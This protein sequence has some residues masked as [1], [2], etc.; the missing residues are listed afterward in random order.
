MNK[1]IK[2]MNKNIE[3][4]RNQI[5]NTLQMLQREKF[6]LYYNDP[7][8]RY[9]NSDDTYTISWNNHKSGRSVSSGCFLR[10]GQYLQIVKDNAYFALL[11]DYS[12][13]RGSFTY[14]NKGNLLCE[15]LLWWP[16]PVNVDR[17]A[18]EELGVADAVELILYE[19]KIASQLRM[20]TP[21]RIDFDYSNDTSEHPAAHMHMQHENCRINTIE[22][23]CFNKFIRYITKCFY[24]GINIK[25]NK[26]DYLSMKISKDKCYTIDIEYENDSKI[27]IGT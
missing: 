22:P 21:I 24:P 27:I 10:I 18:V 26:Y 23:I 6:V 12:I 5:Y 16:C 25:F 2:K 11:S 8:I 14:D 13:I 19:N 17:D 20:R 1:S 9:N 3:N 4:I 15:N 7:N